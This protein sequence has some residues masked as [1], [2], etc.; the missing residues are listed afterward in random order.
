MTCPTCEDFGLIPFVELDNPKPDDAIGREDLWFALCLCERGMTLRESRNAG[1][2]TGFALWQ[3]WA[4]R[5]QVNPE[6]ILRLEDVLTGDELQATGFDSSRS[7]VVNREA[8][9]LAIGR[10]KP[11]KL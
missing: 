10:A 11:V 3:L 1:H 5:E 6:R 4:A 7:L 8:A 9:L 2:S